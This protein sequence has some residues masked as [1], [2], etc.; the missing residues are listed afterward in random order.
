MTHKKTFAEEMHE[1]ALSRIEVLEKER[2]TKNVVKYEKIVNHILNKIALAAKDG[3]LII[4]MYISDIEKD[5]P[6]VIEDVSEF[7]DVKEILI[8]TQGLCVGFFDG[9][10]GDMLP[11]LDISW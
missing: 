11:F 10:D 2:I 5:V 3:E 6:D 1:L 7:D 4:R 9:F 8:K